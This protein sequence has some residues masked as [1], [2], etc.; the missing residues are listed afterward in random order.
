MILKIKRCTSQ[1]NMIEILCM[2]ENLVEILY[3]N[4]K[5]LL[6]TSKI[7]CKIK[8]RQNF[9]KERDCILKLCWRSH[10]FDK[11]KKVTVLGEHKYMQS[12][13]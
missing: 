9:I 7:I 6:T 13:F 11:I 1:V 2:V 8:K 4:I 12:C 10:T 5:K 3:R